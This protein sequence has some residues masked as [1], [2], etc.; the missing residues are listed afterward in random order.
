[1]Q[2]NIPVAMDFPKEKAQKGKAHT[3]LLA[4]YR[5]FRTPRSRGSHTVWRKAAA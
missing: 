1:M 3:N 5:E 4:A 2:G